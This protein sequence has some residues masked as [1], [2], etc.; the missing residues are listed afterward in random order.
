MRMRGAVLGLV[1]IGLLAGAAPARAILGVPVPPV[2]SAGQAQ[3]TAKSLV[4]QP[5]NVIVPSVPDPNHLMFPPVPYVAPPA[6][7]RPALGVLSPTEVLTCQ[8]AY[9]GP[10]AGIVALTVV[11]EKAG[12][13]PVP[14]GFLS[15]AFSPV[16]TLCVAADF[17]K[18]KSCGPDATITGALANHPDVPALPGGVPT[19]DPFADVPAPF[20][21]VVVEVG[22]VQGDLEHYV[23]NDSVRLPLEHKL[24]KQLECS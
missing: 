19:V 18:V 21:T 20:A 5:P 16:V 23:Y 8:V 6:G 17:P 9:L 10:L 12:E 24:S 2:P 1:V 7:L 15:P 13:H 11:M 3:Q 14:P 22:A 4:P